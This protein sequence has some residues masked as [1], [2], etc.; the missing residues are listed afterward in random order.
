MIDDP[1]LIITEQEPDEYD[2]LAQELDVVGTT[3]IDEYETFT[4]QVPISIDCSPLTWWLR[5]EQQGHY[6]NLSKMA[7]DILSIPAMSADPER[8]FSG[9]R[10][11]ISWDRMLLG[12]ATIEKGECLKS[13][14]QSG[15]TRGLP[16]EIID[17]CLNTEVGQ[18]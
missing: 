3:T 6:P 17:E 10:R 5:D 2:I 8:V 15:I 14:I 13:W 1:S 9:A 7:V 12:A 18:P 4:S 16:V 11:T